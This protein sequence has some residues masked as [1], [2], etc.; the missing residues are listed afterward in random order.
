M[1]VRWWLVHLLQWNRPSK[2]S[3]A[4]YKGHLTI[5]QKYDFPQQQYIFKPPR[6]GRPLYNGQSGWSQCVLCLEVPLNLGATSLVLILVLLLDACCWSKRNTRATR[7]SGVALEASVLS[8]PR[9]FIT[10]IRISTG[11]VPAAA[12][13]FGMSSCSP[14]SFLAI[15]LAVSCSFLLSLHF[16]YT[17]LN[18]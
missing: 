4:S 10:G 1:R 12:E 11:A 9:F 13:I 2:K 6:R 17:Y 18:L 8:M 14:F 5:T 16:L 15:L 7:S 3:T